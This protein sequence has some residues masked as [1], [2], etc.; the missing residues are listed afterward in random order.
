MVAG[1]FGVQR[2]PEVLLSKVL[3]DIT[4]RICIGKVGVGATVGGWER[5][6]REGDGATGGLG[7]SLGEQSWYKFKS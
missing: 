2:V 3:L 7:F 1:V 4:Q 6:G 5:V